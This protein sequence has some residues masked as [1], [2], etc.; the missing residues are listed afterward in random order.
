MDV[1]VVYAGGA[2][3]R[4]TWMRRGRGRGGVRLVGGGL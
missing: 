4:E 3:G 1:L 2:S